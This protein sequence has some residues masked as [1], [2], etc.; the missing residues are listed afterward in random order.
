MT[1]PRYTIEPQ[2]E[3]GARYYQTP[4]GKL[5]SVTTILDKTANK[6]D[7]R[8]WVKQVGQSEAQRRTLEAVARGRSFHREME[9]FLTVGQP[10]SS[11]FFRSVQPF[12]SRVDAVALV[13]GTV[14][15]RDGFAGTVDCVA[16][17]DGVLSVIDWKTTSRKKA[18]DAIGDERLQVAAYRAAVQ[19]LYGVEVT[20]GFLVF[21]LPDQQAHVVALDDLDSRYQAFL[22]RLGRCRFHS[23]ADAVAS[24]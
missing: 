4:L 5:P 23:P 2:H 22:L 11:T 10:G 8:E 3:S 20:Q 15:H 1:L 19:A 12:L 21:A 14:W 13:E 7:L 17:V 6:P 24:G 18:S 16:Y 9:E